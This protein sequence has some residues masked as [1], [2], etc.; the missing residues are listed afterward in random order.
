MRSADTADITIMI[1]NIVLSVLAL[2]I[3]LG[4]GLLL[5]RLLV[6][7]LQRTVLDKWIVQTLGV[8][9]ILLLLALGAFSIVGIWNL[10][11][12]FQ[13]LNINQLEI[14]DIRNFSLNCIGT[15]LLI[16]FGVGI[17][18]TVKK[19]TIRGLGE[20]RIDINIRTLVGRVFYFVVLLVAIFWILS[21]WN[22]QL[23]IPVAAI[24]VL[25]VA[26]AVAIQ[27]ILKD[28]VAGFYILLERPF[29]IGD[30]ISVINNSA[31]Y[32][33]KVEDVQLRATKLRLTSGEEVTIPNSYV[34]GGVVTNNSFYGERRAI[35]TI[36]LAQQDFVKE[37]TPG[38]IL[39]A[40]KDF[41]A[42]TVKPEPAVL[43]SGYTNQ[44][45]TLMLRFWITS[46]QHAII[47][48]VV[49]TLHTLLPEAE[50]TVQESAGNI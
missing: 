34:F 39:Q 9:V 11:L 8:L 41:E 16:A 5:R 38:Q 27:D 21:I 47:S 35:I 40:I 43:V 42:I 24:G 44:Q 28:L 46:G 10:N 12:L 33:G 45:I 17:A 30:Q 31:T 6:R 18:R 37:E 25:T 22:V 13:I 49:Y 26:T 14:K 36:N 19:L 23:G 32:T 4:L 50:L 15:G 29:Y 48:D 1:L 7:R 2:L 3:A 20:N